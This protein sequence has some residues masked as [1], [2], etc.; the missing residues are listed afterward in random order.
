[1]TIAERL[2]DPLLRNQYL[3][4]AETYLKLI[5]IEL[6]Q[7]SEHAPKRGQEPLSS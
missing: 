2:G 7:L 3:R 4:V 5:S 6:S 1:M